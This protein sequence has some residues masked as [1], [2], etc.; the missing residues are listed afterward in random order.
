ML[1]V[2]SILCLSDFVLTCDLYNQH[3]DVVNHY[4]IENYESNPISKYL[5]ERGKLP[6]NLIIPYIA[7]CVLFVYGYPR[8]YFHPK[9]YK[10]T[11]NMVYGSQ[12][13]NEHERLK[14]FN[15]LLAKYK[16]YYFNDW[17]MFLPIYFVILIFIVGHVRGIFSYL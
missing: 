10:W 1:F 4:W 11:I 9:A 6:V 17:K 8:F 7:L 3:Y 14:Y 13:I 5:L 2:Y 16:I 15:S 12:F